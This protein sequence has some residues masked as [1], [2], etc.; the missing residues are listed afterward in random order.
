MLLIN[1][2]GVV[3]V[4]EG[5]S[6]TGISVV[7]PPDAWWPGTTFADW[8]AYLRPWYMLND[9]GFT[10]SERAIPA[11]AQVLDVSEVT[12]RLSDVDLA[13]TQLFSSENLAVASY[14]T[15]EV[16][17]TDLS[18]PV[19][20]TTGFASSGVIYL[21]QEAITYTSKTATTFT[22]P[23]G[24]RGAYGSKPSRHVYSVAQ[25]SGL[26]NPQVTDIP[27]EVVGLP[28]TLW[29][30]QLSSSGVI[31]ALALEHYGTIGTGPA[32]VGGGDDGLARCVPTELNR[33]RAR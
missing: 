16:A 27:V 24:G 12:I 18:I 1:G 21:D 4:P 33:A 20:S 29:L 15:A 22:V 30:A 32:L 28:A 8:S 3:I 23:V 10:I 5:V 19:V 17:A 9:D 11:A 25:G 13:A 31:T 26:G 7:A 14:I 6:V 2:V